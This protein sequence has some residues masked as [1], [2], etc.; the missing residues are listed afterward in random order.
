VPSP[1]FRAAP[2]DTDALPSCRAV[3][4]WRTAAAASYRLAGV[5]ICLE[6]DEDIVVRPLS[7]L[8]ILAG[9]VSIVVPVLHKLTPDQSKQ[10]TV[11]TA[12][13]SLGIPA[14]PYCGKELP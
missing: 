1:P 6:L 4:D 13:A 14:C 8:G 9:T 5:P 3:P 7:V 11:A 12:G 10:G 2:R